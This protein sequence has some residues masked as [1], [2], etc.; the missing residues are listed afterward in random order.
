V[1]AFWSLLNDGLVLINLQSDSAAFFCLNYIIC[2]LNGTSMYSQQCYIRAR[3]L[4]HFYSLKLVY[5]TGIIPHFIDRVYKI[6]QLR[7]NEDDKRISFKGMK[8]M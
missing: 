6:W 2:Q 4:K 5:L 7:T 1:I 3:I 8:P